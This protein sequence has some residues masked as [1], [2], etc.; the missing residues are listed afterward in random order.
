[1][2]KIF[3]LFV[4]ATGL[5]A[6]NSVIAEPEIK[7][8]YTT[9]S[10]DCM[11]SRK[12]TKD[13]KRIK[14][15][16]D[17][18]DI[19]LGSDY[20]NIAEEF[21]SILS[22]FDKLGVMIF[23]GSE[24]YFVD[25]HRAVYHTEDN[26]LYLNDAFMMNPEVLI[27]VVRHEGWHVAQDCMAGSINNSLIALIKPEED[28]PYYWRQDVM[29]K[30]P[31]DLW[32]WESEAKWAGSVSWMTSNTLSV[33]ASNTPMWEVYTPNSSTLEWLKKNQFIR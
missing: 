25:G 5:F 29:D 27:T 33:C 18:Q 2:N 3:L 1:M 14:H 23:L 17:L 8:Y 22:S 6:V 11:S 7:E 15:I 10:M 9:E 13:V 20:S 19:Y 24:R 16:S 4:I 30:Y 26:K 12:C 21:N 28:V 32:P 31:E